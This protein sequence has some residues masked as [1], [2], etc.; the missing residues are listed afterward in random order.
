MITLAIQQ[1]IATK[2]HVD[3]NMQTLL[4]LL[5]VPSRADV[6]RLMT[7]LETIQGSLVNLN[8]KVDRLLQGV[9]RRSRPK[10]NEDGQP[11]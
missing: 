4:A 10:Q 6:N 2:G 9:R 8:L 5:S 1:A 7:K 3:R 11:P